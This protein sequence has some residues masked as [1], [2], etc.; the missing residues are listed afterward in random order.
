MRE[1]HV[2]NLRIESFE[3]LRRVLDGTNT[4]TVPLGTG[5]PRG[6][7]L[8]TAV[9][10]VSLTAGELSAEIRTRGS[11]ESSRLSLGMKLDS[12][13][14]HFSFRSGREVLPGDVYALVR[15]DDV[16]YRVGGSLRYVFISLS[17]EL[18]LRLGGEDAVSGNRG[19]WEQRRWFCASPPIRAL[20][21]RS[22]ETVVRQFSQPDW[23]VSGP[24]IRQLQCDLVEP[25]LWGYLFCGRHAH[26]RRPLASSAIVRSVEG[27]VDGQPP[28]SIHLADLC[29]ALRLS[30]RT[31]QRAFTETLGM[32]PARYLT[33]RRLAAVRAVLR[34]SGPAETTVTDAAIRHGFWE[35]GR[36]AR[37][38]QRLFG[39]RPSQTLARG[40]WSRRESVPTW[41]KLH[42]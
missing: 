17:P 34:E 25:F 7:I 27:W 24:A 35:L 14:T 15:G 39:E 29:R 30:R 37:D 11:I 31:L 1:L 4:R 9:G 10:D 40:R 23:P 28:E 2:T 33:L 26:E 42:S 21:V 12:E 3:D 13:S 6:S 22:L 32:G 8:Q 38:Y 18:L 5:I 36:F 41:R 19:F 16:D 20:I